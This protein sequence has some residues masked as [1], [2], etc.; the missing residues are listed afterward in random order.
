MSF[1]EKYEKVESEGK[2]RRQEKMEI[3]VRRVK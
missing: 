2:S 3:E 1:V